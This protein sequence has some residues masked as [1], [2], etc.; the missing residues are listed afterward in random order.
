[1]CDI[2]IS[3]VSLECAG[4]V[5]SSGKEKVFIVY[6]R[7]SD[8]YRYPFYNATLR[9]VKYLEVSSQRSFG[10]FR[11][12]PFPCNEFHRKLLG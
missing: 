12:P 8:M 10:P 11:Q 4:L 7:N 6:A 3:R 2:K 9:W 1:M 5:V